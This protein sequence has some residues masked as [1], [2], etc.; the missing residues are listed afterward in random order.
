[1]SKSTVSRTYTG[2]SH[3]SVICGFSFTRGCPSLSRQNVLKYETLPM[4]Y[5]RK[6]KYNNEAL[7]H[8]VLLMGYLQLNKQLTLKASVVACTAL[9]EDLFSS[10]TKAECFVKD[11]KY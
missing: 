7:R 5:N 4:T 10:K 2:M 3:P 6:T 1:M 11:R 8:C 9:V